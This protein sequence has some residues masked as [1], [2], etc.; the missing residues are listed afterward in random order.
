MKITYKGD[1]A[2]KSLLHLAL[3]YREGQGGVMSIADIGKAGD[4][5]V[6]FLEQI[7]LV[8][9]RG[10][11]VRSKRGASGGFLLARPPT[12]IT[13]GEVVR[14]IEGPLE[15][16][17]CVGSAGYSG[18]KDVHCCIFKDVWNEVRLAT[19]AILDALT[20]EELV[21]RHRARA[22]DRIEAHDYSI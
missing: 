12:E 17:A 10:G 3:R 19:S 18:C 2:L 1:Y 22:F 8:L 4:M 13:V 16:I 6:A 21:A 5:P 9:R 11:F 7:L 20:F 15:P 14:F